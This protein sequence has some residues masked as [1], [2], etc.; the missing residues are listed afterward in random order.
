LSVLLKEKKHQLTPISNHWF[1]L[2]QLLGSLEDLLARLELC[3]Y[4]FRRDVD[5]VH[6]VDWVVGPVSVGRELGK[7]RRWERGHCSSVMVQSFFQE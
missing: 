3:W 2:F 7:I 6:L 1:C 5:G 4:I